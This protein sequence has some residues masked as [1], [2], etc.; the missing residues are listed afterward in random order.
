M[1]RRQLIATGPAT[2]FWPLET[3]VV[4]AD[5]EGRGPEIWFATSSGSVRR[6]R[7]PA[8]TEP[9]PTTAELVFHFPE[10]GPL[11]SGPAGSDGRQPL[12]LGVRN[13]LYQL[14]PPPVA[15][16]AD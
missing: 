1:T 2:E 7:A 12:Y 10:A 15:Q 5:P 9:S 3:Q 16:H 4:R 14:A 11:T 8:D 13:Q 6:W